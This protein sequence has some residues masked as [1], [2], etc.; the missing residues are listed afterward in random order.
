MTPET[1]SY[2]KRYVKL[3][4]DILDPAIDIQER[5]DLAEQVVIWRSYFN[6]TLARTFEYAELET[7]CRQLIEAYEQIRPEVAESLKQSLGDNAEIW[8]E[9]AKH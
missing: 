4:R 7:H 6:Q 1:I 8:T 9:L 2:C 3:C 5:M